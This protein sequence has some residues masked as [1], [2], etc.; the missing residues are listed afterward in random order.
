M[1]FLDIVDDNDEV[2]GNAP[3]QEI[4]EKLLTHRI[5][6]ILI[7]NNKGEMALQLQGRNKKFCPLH[8]STAVGGHVQAGESYEQAA[9][10]ECEEELGK[11]VKPIFAFKDVFRAGQ[12]IKKFLVTFTSDYNGPFN[13]NEKEVENVEFFT[14]QKIREMIN[15]GE[16]FHPELLFLLKKHYGMNKISDS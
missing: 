8:W 3:K 14:M 12:G 9:I 6:H 1:E 5:V 15:A 2:L 13:P 4:Y 7:F 16:K 10:R 11:R